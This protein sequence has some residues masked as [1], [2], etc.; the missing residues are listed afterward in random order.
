M[1]FITS[2]RFLQAKTVWGHV[3][4]ESVAKGTPK[5]LPIWVR[6]AVAGNPNYSEGVQRSG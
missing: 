4:L 1:A 5:A 3:A 2:F 6:E